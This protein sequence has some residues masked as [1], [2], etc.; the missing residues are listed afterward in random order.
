MTG[1]KGVH[2]FLLRINL[3]DLEIRKER[4]PDLYFKDFLG[5]RGL[6]VRYLTAE[7]NPSVDPFSSD[8]KIIIATGPITGSKVPTSGRFSAITK[9]QLTGTI[10]DCNS[11][12]S[13]GVFLKGCGIDAL[14]LEGKL[15]EPGCVVITPGGVDVIP[16]TDLWGKTTRDTISS[17][18]NRFGKNSRVCCI[19]PAG[20]NRVYYA[21]IIND[22][23]HALGRGGLGAVMGSKKV[24]AI[25]ANI[26]SRDQGFP[27]EVAD[28][29]RLEMVIKEIHKRINA[30]PVTGKGL[31]LFGT[32]QL[33]N[34]I[35][36]FGLFPVRNFQAGYIPDAEN[37]SGE[38]IR[39]TIFKHKSAC[40]MCPIACGRI[41]ATST[42]EG[43]GPEYESDW[44][45]GADCGIFDLETVTNANYECNELG[46]DTITAGATI[47]CAMELNQLGC[48]PPAWQDV[49]FGARDILVSLIHKIAYKE[50]IGSDLS[51]G[52]K[53]LAAK[54]GME[55][56]AMH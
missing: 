8:N 12:G 49:K 9:S 54:F 14:I 2:G 35:N 32:P 15:D 30:S 50:G 37:L 4:I 51:E 27:V 7:V 40:Y 56:V 17:L 38:R 23:H 6:G 22:F 36:H 24:K 41:T 43:K 48:L 33:V 31:P 11:G 13:F 1:I 53:R 45:L 18:K 28:E 42:R 44:A 5:G 19:G 16:A 46:L 34:L 26:E 47:A 25:V 29:S 55:H 20:E 39:E 3:R 21:N 52:S 10:L